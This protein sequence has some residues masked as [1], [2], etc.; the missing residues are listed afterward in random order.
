MEIFFY[1]TSQSLTLTIPGSGGLTPVRTDRAQEVRGAGDGGGCGESGA[2]QG[3]LS[4][5]PS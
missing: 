1:V 2:A 4:P 5:T 3:A